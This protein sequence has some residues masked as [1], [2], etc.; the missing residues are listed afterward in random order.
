MTDGEN[1]KGASLDR[2]DGQTE[3]QAHD[4]TAVESKKTWKDIAKQVLPWVVTAG[5]LIYIFSTMDL[6]KFLET[7]KDANLLFMVLSLLSIGCFLFL[8]DAYIFSRLISWF[9]A[10][11]T[12]YESMTLRGVGLLLMNININVGQGAFLYFV[13]RLKKVSLK[14]LLGIQFYFMAGDF[15]AGLVLITGAT[16]YLHLTDPPIWLWKLDLAVLGGWLYVV[17]IIAYWIFKWDHFVLG[18]FRKWPILHAYDKSTPG[19]W[20][21]L[22]LFR[23]VFQAVAFCI[24]IVAIIAFDADIPIIKIILLG[25]IIFMI[26]TLPVSVGGVGTTQAA[27]LMFFREYASEEK[28]IGLSLS[29][30]ILFIIFHTLIGLIFM[31]RAIRLIFGETGGSLKDLTTA[32]AEGKDED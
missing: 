20:A 24:N 6:G 17:H 28:L 14:D 32:V 10:G 30:N 1:Y 25:P 9:S 23:L 19:Q 12:M 29:I 18:F 11:F 22:C 31:K 16:A 13:H 8:F 4:H 26:S 15:F 2:A 5:I 3:P 7:L 21:K 27:W